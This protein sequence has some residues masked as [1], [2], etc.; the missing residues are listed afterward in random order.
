MTTATKPRGS[1]NGTAKQ[2]PP[3]PTTDRPGDAAEMFASPQRDVRTGL[4]I[5]EHI[6]PNARHRITAKAEFGDIAARR[7]EKEK[8]PQDVRGRTPAGNFLHPIFFHPEPHDFVL[9]PNR[10]DT[11]R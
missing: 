10:Q 6:S 7:I 5:F 9:V 8:I 3:D 1:R 2:P 11:T 4:F